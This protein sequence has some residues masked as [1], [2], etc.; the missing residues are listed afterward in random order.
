MIVNTLRPTQLRVTVEIEIPEELLNRDV[1]VD[2]VPANSSDVIK[3]RMEK[4]PEIVS[5]HRVD[6]TGLTFNPEELY[7]HGL[8]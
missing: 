6:L 5:K 3:E 1:K 2:L 4:V 8:S 7:D